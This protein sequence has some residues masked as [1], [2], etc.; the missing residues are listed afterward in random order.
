MVRKLWAL[1]LTALLVLTALPFAADAATEEDAAQLYASTRRSYT[2]S[3]AS[4]GKESFHGLCGTMVAYQL[5]KMGVT[6]Y[7]EVCNGNQIYDHFA[8]K[9]MTSGGYY[10]NAYS[11]QEY[12]LEQALNEISR[13]GTRDVRN[14]LVGFQWTNTEAGSAFGHCCVINGILDG[15]VYFVESFHTSLGGAEGSVIRCSIPQF[16]KF[17]GDW[18]GFEGCV[19]FSESYADTLVSYGTDIFVRP[20]FSMPLRSQPCLL[21][22]QGCQVLRTVSAGERLRVNRVLRDN[23]G[24]YYYQVLDGDHVGYIIAQAAV[25][26]RTNPEELT[27]RQFDLP[28]SVASA[29]ELTVAGQIQAQYGLV[30][31]IEAVVTDASGETILRHRQVVDEP[32]FDLSD[33]ELELPELKNGAYELTINA[34]TASAYVVEDRLDYSYASKQLVQQTFWIGPA[35]RTDH[36]QPQLPPVEKPEGWVWKNGVWYCYENGQPC[37]GWVKNMGVRYYLQETGAVTTGWAEIDGKAYCFSAT[38]ALCV[39]WVSTAEGMRYCLANGQFAD[40]WQT[41]DASRYY[42][43]EGLLQ[44]QGSRIEG[45]VEYA[46]QPDGRAVRVENAPTAQ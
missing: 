39:G 21:G 32:V 33:L 27:T 26:E 12:T 29:E 6:R 22:Q 10:V 42:F 2:S 43:A 4:A 15:T 40:G 37:T 7:A 34:D 9:D 19:Y 13:Y 45:D 3:L 38:G 8:R 31:E 23:E 14:I 1:M 25:L 5:R 17:Y 28:L 18:T 35:P 24:T 20:R 16:A 46:F 36:L 30:G 11:A 44:T 41:I